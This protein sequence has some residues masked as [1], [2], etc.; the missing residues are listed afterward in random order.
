[1]TLNFYNL[2]EQPFGTLPDA[3]FLFVSDSHRQALA[4]VIVALQQGNSFVSLLARPGMGKTTLLFHM[5]QALKQNVTTVY[6]FH[7]PQTPVDFLRAILADL[8]VREMLEVPEQMF[9]L[10]EQLLADQAQQGK[11]V[12]VII[13]E[14]QG[15]TPSVSELLCVLSN[16][17]RPYGT[18]VQ[19]VFSGHS[20][21]ED[22]EIPLESTSLSYREPIFA[23][24]EPLNLDD[25]AN[26]VDYRL[27]VA[28]YDRNE[29][30]FTWE[31][32]AL[33][34]RYGEGI[35]RKINNLCYTSL[36][37][38]YKEKLE[39]IEADTVRGVIADL[40][41]DRKQK[42]IPPAPAGNPARELPGR[43]VPESWPQAEPSR[44][45][46]STWPS[47]PAVARVPA[48]R[49]GTQP[50]ASVSRPSRVVPAAARGGGAV[51]PVRRYPRRSLIESVGSFWRRLTSRLFRRRRRRSRW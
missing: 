22:A 43:T 39:R 42:V 34:A 29:P 46:A 3:R 12:V 13:D 50:P 26:Y 20:R 45:Y 33:I 51:R 40:G 8:G 6:L 35:P 15:L 37:F 48:S 30:L 18:R 49:R 32:S 27:R 16:P 41:L 38:G 24:L 14:A 23:R 21:M 25:T 36:T 2:K 11:R 10:L 28:G 5:F 7:A 4:A 44:A 1:M 19:F 17:E 9:A 47:T 31:A